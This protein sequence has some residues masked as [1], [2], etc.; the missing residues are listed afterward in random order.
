MWCNCRESVYKAEALESL[1]GQ[2]RTYKPNILLSRAAIDVYQHKMETALYFYN[3]ALRTSPAISEYISVKLGVA[4]IKGVEGFHQSALK[5]MENLMPILR[6][7]EPRLFFDLLNSYATELSE[8]GRLYEARNVMRTVIASPFIH[9]YPEWRE[10]AE[11]LKPAN[12]SFVAINPLVGRN[13]LRFRSTERSEATKASIAKILTFM[14]KKDQTKSDEPKM[15][16]AE[17]AKWLR[18][19]ILSDEFPEDV[20][21]EIIRLMREHDQNR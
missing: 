13:V 18:L 4:Q 19:Q 6:H 20:L 7:V 3:E 10:T 21:D 9:A 11:E 8:V 15:T 5:D 1:A 2:T 12:R 16:K 17:K 14:A